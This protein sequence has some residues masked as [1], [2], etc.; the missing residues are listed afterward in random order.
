MRLILSVAAV[1]TAFALPNA[2]PAASAEEENGLTI[3][4]T[5]GETVLLSLSDLDELAQV[6]FTTSTIWTDGLVTFSGVPVSSVLSSAGVDGETLRMTALNDYSVEAP[7]DEFG[8]TYPIIATRMDGK[9]ISIREK[10]PF[11]VVYPYDA[12]P[13][14]RTETAHARSIWQLKGISVID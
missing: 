9:T 4:S 5:T 12:D 8:E 10:G 14:F 2:V 1:I 6:E 3:A 7:L 13:S 11:W